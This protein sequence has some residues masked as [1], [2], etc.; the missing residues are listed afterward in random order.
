MQC[1]HVHTWTVKDLFPDPELELELELQVDP[2]LEV[3]VREATDIKDESESMSFTCKNWSTVF[4]NG[5]SFGSACA[6]V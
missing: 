1:T 2:H 6:R 3:E 4:E 5:A